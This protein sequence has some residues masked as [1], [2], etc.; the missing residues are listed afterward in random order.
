MNDPAYRGKE[1]A[2]R[3]QLLGSG[4]VS[5][6]AFSSSPMTAIW[7]TTGGYEWHGKDPNLDAEFVRCRVSPEYGKTVGWK[8]IAGRDYSR[9]H[10]TDAEDAIIIS[11]TAAEYMGM[12]N[13]IGQTL[14]DVD[15]FGA[16]K[17]TRTIIG[18]VDDIIMDSPYEPV[19]Q[20]IFLPDEGNNAM[21]HVRI[22]PDRG[23]AEALPIIEGLLNKVVPSALFEYKFVDEDYATKF[24]Q[25]QRVGELA[26][27]FAVLAIFI[28]CLG[29]FGLASFVAERRTK[30]IGIRKI[31][32][33]S[34]SKLWQMLASDFV[35]LVII[36]CIIAVPVGYYL[37]TKWLGKYEFRTEITGWL[38]IATCLGAL[39]I[40]LLTVSY[41][42]IRA[43]RMNPVKSL[44]SE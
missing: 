10:K 6:V 14:T 19:M 28:S 18:V 22:K 15:E 4:V 40:T 32:G 36:S 16:H 29:L 25:E 12:K 2:I 7:N 44:R 41:H 23:A 5:D 24:S 27:V 33:A 31:M 17:W 43:A 37:M 3:T 11:K 13:P 21:L 39:A 42:S 26:G 30:E 34:V 35:L 8:V 9:E 20:A 1:D 38:L